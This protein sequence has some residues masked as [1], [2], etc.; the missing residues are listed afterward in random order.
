MK[1]RLVERGVRTPPFIVATTFE[2][3]VDAWERFGR[4]CMV[5]M[6]DFAASLNI[7]RVVTRKQLEHA[8]ETIVSNRL[9]VKGFFELSRE[10]LLEEFVQGRELTAEGYIQGDQVTIFSISVRS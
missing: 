1:R 9:G 10:V 8:W 2:Q 7:F 6:V 5:K 4:D 3:A